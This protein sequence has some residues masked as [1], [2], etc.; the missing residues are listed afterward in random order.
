M[1]RQSVVLCAL[2]AV[3]AFSTSCKQLFTTSF[4]AG[5]ARTGSVVSS[6]A[7]VSDLLDIAES[8]EAADKQ[9]ATDILNALATKPA[10]VANLTTDEQQTVLDLALDA[11]VEM[12]TVLD[13]L[14]T[15]LDSGGA[16]SSTDVI[17]AILD[18]V[19]TSV[20]LTA[21][22]AI[23]GDPTAAAEVPVASLVT[24]S[25]AVLADVAETVGSATIQTIMESAD[26]DAAIAAATGLTTEQKADVQTVVDLM[27]T[28]NT[29][30]QDEL[31]ALEFGG[32][33][34]GDY[35]T[36]ATLP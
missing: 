6:T 3:V 5:L 8:G 11:T 12:S 17:N 1:K 35:L 15:V 20:D 33:N 14:Q 9:V 34:L 2:I 32:Y 22:T 18:S 31:A 10:D 24:A 21:V 36:G 27:D 25:V 4:G 13:A 30:R 7:T 28:L 29:T 19:N 23:L 16:T 26:R